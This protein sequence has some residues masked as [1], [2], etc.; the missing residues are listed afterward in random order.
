MKKK[1]LL[2]NDDGLFAPGLT[3]LVDELHRGGLYD[4]RVVAPEKEQS[5]VGHCITIHWPLYAERVELPE[6]IR[7]VPAY[8]VA[9]TPADCVKL[10]ITNLF[11]D[12]KPDIVISGIN[13]G[14]NVGMNVLYS[15]TVGGAL[16]AVINGFPAIALSLDIPATGL[17][18]FSLAAEVSVPIIAA[19]LE[20]GIPEWS[21]LN[22]NIPNLPQSE[23]K[24]TRLTQHG[25][26]GFKEF[27]V[28]EKPET[29]N[30][31]KFRLE[32]SMAYRDEDENIDALA[33]RAGYVSV[34]A[35]G[36]CMFNAPAHDAF[37]RWPLFDTQ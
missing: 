1:I 22:V 19:A 37:S 31:R 35:L 28:E 13:R 16:E 27:Y 23:L 12:F 8:H 33:L 17:W 14:P 9:G 2:T 29:L 32:G 10:A 5:G 3:T 6:P 11:P 4:L 15:G 7:A 25:K 26:S 18:H 20:H 24:G 36:T 30:R 34:T 21:A